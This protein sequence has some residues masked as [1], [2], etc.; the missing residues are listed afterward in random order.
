MEFD[1]TPEEREYRDNVRRLVD[2]VVAED[3]R[4][5][6]R[7][8]SAK[9]DERAK[10]V[11][12]CAALRDRGW[13][14]PHWPSEYGGSDASAWMHVILGEELWSVGEPR[15]PQY[16][17]VNWIGPAIMAN[18]TEDQKREHLTRIAAGEAFWC[19]GFS[20]PDAGSD[21][22]SLR[23]TAVRDGDEYVINGQKIWT[24]HTQLA[25]WCFLLARTDSEVAK[26]KGISIFLFP[27]D[28]P[29]VEVRRVP[30]VA[31]E[32]SFAEV[33]LTDVRVGES[34][35][36]GEENG[37]WGIVRQALQY[38]RV[39]APRWERAS[40]VLDALAAWANEHGRLDEPDV[41][42]LLGQAKAS[43]EAA[44]LLAYSVIDERAKGLPP[45]PQ[46]Y[47]ARVGMVRCERLVAEASMEILGELSVDADSLSGAN[48]YPTMTAGVAAGA[49][50]IQLN[51]V[52]T[53]L[54]GLPRS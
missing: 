17:S 40:R 6:P 51:L 21:L 8:R 3:W 36:L 24:S 42:R 2:E 29:G 16:M 22:A 10:V 19:Q 27:M 37:G 25:E 30:N 23:T 1:W 33:F 45:S 9:S 20:E 18:G 47:A 49:Y 53:M 48:Y 34:A 35:R 38:E 12:F 4:L 44:R 15:G 14:T 43:C 46:A 52:A 50:E 11:Q 41:Q 28:T 39:G 32:S 13:L 31:G 26:H 54:L 7:P 5:V